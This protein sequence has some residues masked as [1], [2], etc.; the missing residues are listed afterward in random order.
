MAAGPGLDG[1]RRHIEKAHGLVVTQ[2]ISLHHFHRLQLLEPGLLCY[3][4]LSGVGIMLK[5][6]HIGYIPH[7]THFISKV[8]EQFAQ[9]IVSNSG[10][11]RPQMSVP[12]NRRAANIHSH[13]AL[14]DRFKEFFGTRKRIGKLELS[15]S[16]QR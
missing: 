5:M 7:I 10:A 4:V 15:H 8:P 14:L 11:C 1:G 9:H 6:A 13:M 2:G 3:L 12:I 16:V